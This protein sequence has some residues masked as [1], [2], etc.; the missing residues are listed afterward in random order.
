VRPS[1]GAVRTEPDVFQDHHRDEFLRSVPRNPTK[2]SR[3]C[4]PCTNRPDS[5]W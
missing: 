5:I 2:S 3:M 4:W 1:T